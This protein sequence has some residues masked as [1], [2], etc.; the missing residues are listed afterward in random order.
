MQSLFTQKARKET[1]KI[2]RISDMAKFFLGGNRGPWRLFAGEGLDYLS[3]IF[4]IELLVAEVVGV[5]E[6]FFVLG[7]GF[8]VVFVGL[9]EEGAGDGDFD[10]LEGHLAGKVVVALF[11]GEVSGY[12]I[13]LFLW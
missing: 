9:V 5:F 10:L 6:I 1:A 2:R 7:V 11:L 12:F 4:D 3:Q 13:E 8:E